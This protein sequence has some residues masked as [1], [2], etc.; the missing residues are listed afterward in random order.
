M[1]A[2]TVLVSED[3][4]WDHDHFD[5][6][7]VGSSREV[8]RGDRKSSPFLIDKLQ[9]LGFWACYRQRTRHLWKEGTWR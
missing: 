4:R 1:K 3:L 2:Q 7:N 8:D 6:R 5:L 9:V